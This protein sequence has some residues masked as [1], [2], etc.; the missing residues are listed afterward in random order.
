MGCSIPMKKKALKNRVCATKP[1]TLEELR[2][3]IEHAI[4]NISLAK[5]QPVCR[6]ARPHCLR[7]TLAGGGRFEH[8]QA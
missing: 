8:I 3:K 4:N 1:Q 7:S 2:D 5:L 6:S